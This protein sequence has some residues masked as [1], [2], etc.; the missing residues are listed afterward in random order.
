MATS[1]GSPPT[2]VLSI[3]D[4]HQDSVLWYKIHVFLYDLRHFR[5]S[6]TSQAR[7]ELVVDPS[8]VGA[9]Y[10]TS[11]ES[12]RILNAH[13]HDGSRKKEG[14]RPL[15]AILDDFFTKRLES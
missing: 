14:L 12:Q 10:F 3:H 4:L 7:L 11:G 6:S 15:N 1:T 9:P 8:Y 2:Q 5:S 13:V